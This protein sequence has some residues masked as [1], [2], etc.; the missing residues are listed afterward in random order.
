M[1]MAGLSL[2]SDGGHKWWQLLS[3]GCKFRSSGWNVDL[4]SLPH[5]ELRRSTEYFA[6][7]TL[8]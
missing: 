6:V 8:P 2:S 5:V 7:G 4:P 3:F 1:Y